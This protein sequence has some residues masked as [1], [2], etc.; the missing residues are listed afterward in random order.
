MLHPEGI[1]HDRVSEWL[2]ANVDGLAPPFAFT[3]VAGGRSNLTFKVEDA[4][5]RAVV[6]RR[7]PLSSV[8]AT[9]HDVGREFKIISALGPTPVPVPDALAHCTDPDV[10]DAPFYVMSFVDGI[11][12]RDVNV[13]RSTTTPETRKVMGNSL[14]DV[15]ADLHSID[16]DAVGLGDLGRKDG[17]IERQLKRWSTQ[18]EASRTR[19]VPQVM[20][21]HERLARA[22]PEQGP[23][24]IAHGD[25]RLDNCVCHRD[26]PLAAVLDWELCTLGD[27]LADLGMLVI[28]WAQADDLNGARPD[29]ATQL[30]G[31]PTRDEVVARYADRTGRDVS[32]LSYYC[33]FQYWRLACISEG[34]YARYAAGAMGDQR[35]VDVDVLSQGTPR[36]AAL[37]AAELEG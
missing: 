7:P 5:G 13:G 32:A 1:D 12:V 36:L 24:A 35:D 14:V 26:G 22:V 30:P 27:P 3:L 18:F 31:F 29:A 28:T 4:N 34:V 10:N 25:Y 16:P 9:A 17:Y 23:A 6:L 37:A 33:A 11:I 2:T 21:V 19:E 20:E 15:L 8:L